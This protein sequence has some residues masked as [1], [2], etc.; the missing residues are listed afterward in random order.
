MCVRKNRRYVEKHGP[1]T[2]TLM[3][4]AAHAIGRVEGVRKG[5]PERGNYQCLDVNCYLHCRK[6][7]RF[8]ETHQ[9][10]LAKRPE[11][12]ADTLLEKLRNLS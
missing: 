5:A 8:R 2:N 6:S 12:R 1:I 9:D 4:T 3:P 10:W 7:R 11:R